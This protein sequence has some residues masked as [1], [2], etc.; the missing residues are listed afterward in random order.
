VGFRPGTAVAGSRILAGIARALGGFKTPSF[1][2]AHMAHALTLIIAT[3]SAEIPITS[4]PF[5]AW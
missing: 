3:A 5:W 2:D 4:R 1:H